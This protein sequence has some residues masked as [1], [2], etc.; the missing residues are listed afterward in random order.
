MIN[1]VAVILLV[2]LLTGVVAVVNGT[3]DRGPTHQQVP[4][5]GSWRVEVL[6][7]ISG[8]V[9]V[10]DSLS[11]SQIL[12]LQLACFT[13][14]TVPA[15]AEGSP[16]LLSD[17]PPWHLRVTDMNFLNESMIFPWAPELSLPIS[18]PSVIG[19]LVYAIEL[20]WIDE[21]N[22]TQTIISKVTTVF[23][24]LVWSTSVLAS[25]RIQHRSSFGHW[26]DPIQSTTATATDQTVG[27][28]NQSVSPIRVVQVAGGS[29]DGQKQIMIE[30]WR[31]VDPAV[32]HF[33]F[34]W[35]CPG[36]RDVEDTCEV[37]QI[38]ASALERNPH[39]KFVKWYPV[40]VGTG[41]IDYNEPTADGERLIDFQQGSGPLTADDFMAYL[42]HRLRATHPPR[43]LD[44]VRP[45][46]VRALWRRFAEP[47]LSSFWPFDIVVQG[48]NG[49]TAD[50]LIPEIG[51]ACG[52]RAVLLDVAASLVRPHPLFD[53]HAVV[54]PSTYAAA[55]FSD[56]A[57]SSSDRGRLPRVR[58]IVPP[59]VDVDSFEEEGRRGSPSCPPQCPFVVGEGGAVGTEG[60]PTVEGGE[61]GEAEGGGKAGGRCR[62]DCLVVGFVGR[63]V[64]PKAPGLFLLT[65]QRVLEQMAVGGAE[66]LGGAG[67]VGGLP[68]RPRQVVFLVV[69]AG[70]LQPSLEELASRLGIRNRVH[71]AGAVRQPAIAAWY[72]AMDVFVMPSL[73]PSETFGIVLIEAMSQAVPVVSLGVFGQTEA[74][75]QNEGYC[76]D[77]ADNN[78]T[79]N[80]AST[81]GPDS[82]SGVC[83]EGRSEVGNAVIVE[84]ATPEALA[85]AVVGLLVNATLRAEVGANARRTVLERFTARRNGQAMALVYRALM[86][87]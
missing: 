25:A 73:M 4:S 24:E 22:R 68:S 13:V 51:L 9:L 58:F 62:A 1:T 63:L 81:V 83:Q 77:R 21:V 59:G 52:A 57:T 42:V 20:L 36:S 47:L 53:Y 61:G 7:P 10:R 67:G 74:I 70:P 39:V 3:I 41:D 15:A 76:V 79:V 78:S 65:A 32:V 29:F 16:L 18:D 17:G 56:E 40:T 60:G 45:L 75:G 34:L 66:G 12:R 6:T 72:A 71:F 31:S 50:L 84:E 82:T 19:T 11:K 8:S 23:Y 69:G 64:S 30:Q 80:T 49:G 14:A 38:V 85:R 5:S 33:L 35:V 48:N 86:R 43:T 55:E 46:W 87:L 54:A 44:A 2:L 27:D 26:I 37:D 28:G